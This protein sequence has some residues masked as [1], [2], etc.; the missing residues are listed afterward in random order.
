MLKRNLALDGLRGYA[1]FAVVI[2]HSILYFDPTLI[3]RIL[4]K[5]FHQITGAYDIVTK[6]CFA[7]FNGETAV[8]LFFILSG[9]VLF[10]SLNTQREQKL[11]P[12]LINFS[13]RRVIRIYPAL[14]FCLI[15]FFATFK[16]LNFFWPDTYHPFSNKQFIENALLYN[17]T[18]H[19]AS[20]TLKIE[21]LAIPFILI[22]FYAYR[23]LGIAGLGL[24]L[25]Y[26]FFAIKHHEFIFNLFT[27]YKCLFYFAFGL[28]IPTP[29][30][31]RVFS[32]FRKNDWIP[33]LLMLLFVRHVFPHKSALGTLLQ[34]GFAFLLVGI[35]YHRRSISFNA[36][37]ETKFSTYLGKISYSFYL[38]N[39]IFLDM[40][41]QLLLRQPLASTHYLES[42]ILAGLFIAALTIPFAHFSEKYIERPSVKLG[43]TIVNFSL[44]LKP[45]VQ[46]T[47]TQ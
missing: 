32:I 24:F 36:F 1:A 30:A 25:L 2:Y 28:I 11:L 7:I 29:A 33:L 35:V 46:Q 19:G 4:Y 27:L 42:G 10:E 12:T 21:I 47:Q 6:I 18:M 37:L 40:V 31:R 9:A 8:I 34:G 13:I 44:F 38:L 39:V 45:Q 16:T 17:T 15:L 43:R 26:S 23:L 22:G 20:W 14:I 5:P 3:N 41:C